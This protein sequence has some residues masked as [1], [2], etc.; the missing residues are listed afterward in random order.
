MESFKSWTQHR[1][2]TM[3]IRPCDYYKVWIVVANIHMVYIG[4]TNFMTKDRSKLIY[5][6]VLTA[7]KLVL[8]GSGS[9][10]PTYGMVMARLQFRFIKFW[11]KNRT[12]PDF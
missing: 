4:T 9:V 10:H 5:K 12:G 8:D 2:I 11:S 6:L 3:S 1:A 7:N